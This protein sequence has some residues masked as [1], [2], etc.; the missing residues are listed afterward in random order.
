LDYNDF[1]SVTGKPEQKVERKLLIT[2]VNAAE[3]G[4]SYSSARVWVPVGRGVEGSAYEFNAA[5]NTRTD[6]LG[7]TETTVD[8]T[9]PSQSLDPMTLRKGNKVQL[10]ISDIMSRRALSELSLF[11]VMVVHAYLENGILPTDM[12]YYAEVQ[13]NC[14]ISPS[15]LGGSSH[16]DMPI[17][18]NY[19]NDVTYGTVSDLKNPTFA[20]KA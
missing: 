17:T 8:N 3:F 19:S 11:E 2:Y 4:E 9:A 14:T 1:L 20:P 12:D 13:K 10:K 16:V 7:I 15:S 5:V 18:I 6:I